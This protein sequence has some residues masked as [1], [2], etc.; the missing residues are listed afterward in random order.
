MIGLLS[1]F[2]C[3]HS[4]MAT[5]S[6]LLHT[7][8]VCFYWWLR[9]ILLSYVICNCVRASIVRACVFFEFDFCGTQNST[10][11]HYFSSSIIWMCAVFRF[12]PL[13]IHVASLALRTHK[14]LG[15][16]WANWMSTYSFVLV[17][18]YFFVSECVSNS[19]NSSIEHQKGEKLEN[20]LCSASLMK[21]VFFW[22][23]KLKH[24]TQVIQ[25]LNLLIIQKFSQEN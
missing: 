7:F 2:A 19:C 13:S 17:S 15:T 9:I 21:D 10:S 3:V 18:H 20:C 1:A 16:V 14:C 4:A 25:F 23:N 12:Y 8:Y 5:H 11:S 6:I 22:R 24:F